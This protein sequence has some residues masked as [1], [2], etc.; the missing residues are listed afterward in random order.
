VVAADASRRRL[1]SLT[2]A[3]ARWGARNVWPVA[4]DALRPP[5]ASRF[6]AVLLDAPC[7]GLGTLARH[8]DIRWRLGPTD[9]ARHAARQQA[10]LA[11]LAPLVKPGGRLVYAT[12]SVEPEETDAVVRPFLA[13]WPEFSPEPV[14][15]W[16]APFVD[17]GFTRT[18]PP[19]HRGDAFFAARLRRAG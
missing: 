5:F 1:S 7:S 8:P 16:A 10:L 17:G 15:A 9:I 12:C 18:G 2:R 14:P 6:D 13:A 3:S 11:A 19:R 4:A